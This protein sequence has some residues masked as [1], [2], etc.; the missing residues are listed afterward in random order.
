[1]TKDSIS[2]VDNF[3][4]DETFSKIENE[5]MSEILIGIIKTL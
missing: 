1:M 5:F 3:L 4:D 2:I